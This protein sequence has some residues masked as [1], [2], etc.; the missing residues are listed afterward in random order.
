MIFGV[1]DPYIL[2]IENYFEN[3]MSSFS[4]ESRYVAHA[5]SII[6]YGVLI[7]RC[8]SQLRKIFVL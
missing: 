7:W 1:V 8:S 3:Q 2:H 4:M 5:E 6:T